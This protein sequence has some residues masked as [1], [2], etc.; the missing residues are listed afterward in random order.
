[1]KLRVVLLT[2]LL[3]SL[4]LGAGST[5][6][7]PQPTAIPTK[8]AMP[9]KTTTKAVAG[10]TDAIT[11]PGLLSYQGKLT[12]DTAGH[13][14][15]D[16][17]YSVSFR[18]Y[19]VASGG[20]SFWDEDQTVWTKHGLFS[21]LL[22]SVTRI[23]SVPDSG[24]LYLGMKV[25]AD[26]EMT[27]RLQIASAAYSFLARKADTANYAVGTGA[28]DSA[29]I[30]TNSYNSAKL[31]GEDTTAFVRAGQAN[32]I[33]SS[34]I[35]D[36]TILTADVAP[37]FKAP[38]SDTSDYAR[39]AP[40]VDSARIAAD[41]WNAYRLQGKDTTALDARYVNEGQT[42]GGDLTGTYPNPTVGAGRI[43]S[44][45][46]AANAVTS[47][48]ILDGTI[49]RADVASNFKAPYSDTSDYTRAAPAVDS[50]R[51]AAN[52]WNAY[53][54][55]GKDTTALDARYVNEGQSA[56]GDMAGSYPNP[57]IAQKGAA[58]GQVLKWSGSAWAPGNDSVGGD[59]DWVHGS[60]SVLYTIRQLGI[61]RGGSC[62]TL[63]GSLASTH[64]NLGFA[65]TTGT[66]GQDFGYCTVSG[67]YDNAADSGYSTVC[68]GGE[69]TAS[70]NGNAV[71]GGWQNTASGDY[72]ATVGGGER[73]TASGQGGTVGGGDGDT[74]SDFYATVG[75]GGNNRACSSYTTVGGGDSNSATGSAATVAGGYGNTASYYYATVGGGWSNSS[76]SGYATVAGGA[77]NTASGFDA[78]VGGGE[79]NNA[80]RTVATVSGGQENTA[81][82]YGAFE[83]GGQLNTV[84]GNNAVVAG[85][86]FNS[87][88]GV[89]VTVSGGSYNN[90]SGILATVGGGHYDTA[91]GR[92]ATVGGGYLNTAS[93]E[94][95]TVAGGRSDSARADYSFAVGY[96][97]VVPASY[98][99]SAAFNGTAATAASQVRC[100]NLL[101]TGTKS[102]AI[103]DPLDPQGK[104]L[105]HY[106]IESPEVVN[107]YRGAAILGADGRAEVQLPDYFS[108]ENTNPMIQVSGIGTNDA[109][110]AQKVQG[111]SFVIG[112]K[113]GTEVYWTVTAQRNDQSAR[114]GQLLTPVEQPKTGALAGRSLDDDYLVGC[115]QQLEQMGKAGEFSFRTAAGRQRYEDMLNQLREA[116]QPGA[117]SEQ[118]QLKAA[119]HPQHPARLPQP[120]K[121][122]KQPSQPQRPQ[123]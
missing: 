57:T 42:A 26:P 12:T 27:P 72:Y 121:G 112:G 60:D 37:N 10:V 59:N 114:I 85:G 75:G 110:I 13:A 68:G 53:K 78:T 63:F 9:V 18:L 95:A 107:L 58:N 73:N 102:F 40:G 104:I 43:D 105:N 29:R 32:S 108:A 65:S 90:A 3:L 123:Q 86:M 54:L 69:N 62:N 45:R 89:G 46:L 66:S 35:V 44:T 91:S 5:A 51:I 6:V 33:T 64:T 36:S 20:S 14:V 71:G 98:S 15:P 16:T 77:E 61:A 92:Y 2:V 39:A 47:D 120:P 31:Q 11:I 38:Y 113:P 99:N 101:A 118:P 52:A 55:E 81:S 19:T 50:V 82:G 41:A 93:G 117:Q 84:S 76:D 115:M 67:G 103:D 83:G 4:A 100:N 97:S 1:M 87:A 70:G 111:N 23:S 74:A 24:T 88:N 119:P 116:E 79:G 7:K 49:A 17:A 94:A 25:N 34:M 106:C 22:G 80:A 30:A 96:L 8:T 122:R 56:G 28:A 48:K 109:Y 21:V